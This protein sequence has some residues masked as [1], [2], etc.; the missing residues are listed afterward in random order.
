MTDTEASAVTGYDP[1]RISILKADP[2]FSDLVRDYQKM[3][4]GFLAEFKDRAEMLTLTAMEVVQE[5][6]EDEDVPPASKVGMALEVAKTF[7]D[8]TGHAPV[9]KS[10]NL[11]ASVDF[12]DA[13]SK[14]RARVRERQAGEDGGGSGTP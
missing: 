11:N 4:D 2:T 12:G 3:E 1:S 9:T 6:L 7:A 8:R 14:A 10:V 5:H 13:L